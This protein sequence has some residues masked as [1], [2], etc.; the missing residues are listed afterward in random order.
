MSNII[1][2]PF[3][4]MVPILVGSQLNKYGNLRLTQ[5]VIPRE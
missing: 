4:R 5:L 1:C 2:S 3:L